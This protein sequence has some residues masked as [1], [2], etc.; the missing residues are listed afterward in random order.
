MLTTS[1]SSE[2]AEATSPGVPASTIARWIQAAVLGALLAVAFWPILLSMYGS[3]FDAALYMEHGVL[4]VPAAVYMTWVKRSALARIPC[5]PSTW[6]LV[7]LLLGA[8]LA[9]LGLAAHWVWVG[10]MAFLVSIVGLIVALYGIQMVKELAYPLGILI[11]MVAP[12]SFVYERVTLSLQLLA[13]RLGESCLE[14][15]GYS[16]VRE[17]NI[18]ELAGSKLSIEEACSGLRSLLSITFMCSLYNYFFVSGNPLRAFIL[19]M[20]IPIAILGNIFRIIASGVA[21]QYN[22][23]LL[24]GAWH[25][26]FGYVSIVGAGIGC[27][28]LHFAMLRIQKMRRRA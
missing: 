22:R 24:E 16:V 21:S 8:L 2:E 27:I 6:G 18:L 19:I 20:A 11:F 10:R 17:G 25:E 9:T 23:Q 12:P 15:I 3:W 7:L 14:F 26:A 4:V 1:R 5:A 13:S 28:A